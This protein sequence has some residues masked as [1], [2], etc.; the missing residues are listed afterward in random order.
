MGLV[1][2]KLTMT[3][4][5][6][7]PCTAGHKVAFC[8]PVTGAV[9]YW[10]TP[11][12]SGNYARSVPVGQYRMRVGHDAASLVDA[13]P[14]TAVVPASS[15]LLNLAAIC[16]ANRL[17]SAYTAPPGEW[18]HQHGGEP[19]SADAL[20]SLWGRIDALRAQHHQQFDY[21]VQVYDVVDEVDVYGMLA[22]SGEAEGPQA[23]YLVGY[24]LRYP[25]AGTSGE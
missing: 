6:S 16:A 3:L 23:R 5:G 1:T 9:I 17:G 25:S 12:G 4:T 21:A 2:G 8:S 11:D 7:P 14:S 15:L 13:T 24:A 10:A 20:R 18:E 19:V 22:L